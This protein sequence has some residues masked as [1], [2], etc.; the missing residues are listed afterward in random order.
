MKWLLFATLAWATVAGATDEEPVFQKGMT[1]TH[2]YRP[3]NNLLSANSAASLQHLRHQVYV[4]WIAL[5]PF[6]YQKMAADPGLYFGDDP[7]DAHITHAVRE[8]HRLGMKVML[9]PHIWLRERSDVSWRGTIGMAS[10]EKWRLWFDNYERFILHYAALAEREGVDIYCIGV[11]LAR[12]MKEREADW[13]ALIDKVRGVYSGPL[14]YAANWHGEYD[15]IGIWDALDYV[16]INAFFPLGE[17]SVPSLEQLRQGAGLVADRVEQLH[18]ATGKPVLFTEV[19]F[20]S[21]RGST[22]TP[23]A[24]PRHMEPQV[25]VDLQ[26]RAYQAVLETFWQRPWFYGMYW[27]KW[28]SHLDDG[29]PRNGNFT[30]RGKPA[31]RFLSEW[32]RKTPATSS[33]R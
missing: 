22:V 18:L 4:D 13:R 25:D 6:A 24:W 1:Y 19:G 2:G 33:A 5:N 32:Y 20:K 23:W 31:E 28:F 14:T 15:E 27:W 21:V 7:P 12:T 30:P 29:G 9:K 8:A 16:G 3:Q 17:E 10:E 26:A 11:E